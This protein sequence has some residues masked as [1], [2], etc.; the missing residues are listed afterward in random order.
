M[1]PISRPLS[2]WLKITGLSLAA[3][4]SPLALSSNTAH[5]PV[6]STEKGDKLLRQAACES[7]P[8]KTSEELWKVAE[9]FR[10]EGDPGQAIASL[11]EVTRK[12]PRDIEAAFV[13]AWLLFE[14]GHRRGGREEQNRTREA[15][16]ELKQARVNN[17]SH[18]LMDTE[19]G[20]FYLLRLKAPELAFP[21]YIKARS[22]YDGDFARN[23]EAA[24]VGRKTSIE[25]RIARTAE[26][27]GRKGEAVEASCRAMFFDPDDKEALTRIERL[28]GSCERK[29]V[30]DPRA[31]TPKK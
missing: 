18:W 17:P 22:H 23:V 7:L 29:G 24:S 20:D 3:A 30:K 6:E 1:T 14:D 8:Q 27:I 13:T 19:L 31:S 10:K 25:N 11:R 26:M 9:C 15:L 2:S 28:A 21:E 5:A 16:E 4:L 12:D